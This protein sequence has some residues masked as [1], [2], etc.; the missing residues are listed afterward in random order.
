M[1][2]CWGCVCGLCRAL[3]W[4]CGCGLGVSSVLCFIVVCVQVL[5]LFGMCLCCVWCGVQFVRHVLCV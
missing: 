5:M 1:L 4:L 2:Q 3:V